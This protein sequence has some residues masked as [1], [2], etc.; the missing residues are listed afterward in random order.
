[1]Q[2]NALEISLDFQFGLVPAILHTPLYA[3]IRGGP[4]YIVFIRPTYAG[5]QICRSGDSPNYRTKI[6]ILYDM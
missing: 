4:Q 6:A 5:I 3:D 1:M 2:G